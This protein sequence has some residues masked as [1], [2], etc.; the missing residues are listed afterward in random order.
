LATVSAGDNAAAVSAGSTTWPVAKCSVVS[1][2]ARGEAKSTETN[3]KK[4]DAGVFHV[5]VF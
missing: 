3:R 4:K 2:G 1:F 5:F